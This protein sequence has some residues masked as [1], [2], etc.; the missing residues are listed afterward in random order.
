MNKI[1]LFLMIIL[2]L[3]IVVSCKNSE[4]KVNKDISKR[5]SVENDTYKQELNI[6]DDNYRTYY[7]VFLYSYYDSNG[8]GI[9]DING[10]IEKLDYINDGD[11]ITDTDLGFNGIW[12][13]PIMPSTTYHKYDVTDYYSIDEQYGTI[14]DF[15]YLVKE[16]N[17]RGIKLIIDMIFNHTSSKHPWFLSALQSL[18]IEPCGKETCAH[19][20]LCREHNKYVNYYNFVEERPTSGIYYPTGKGWY[21]EGVFWDQMPDLNLAD[22][23]LRKN[24][25]DVMSFWLNLGVGGFRL[26]AA[27]EYYSGA[28]SKN[29]E[30][31]S[32]ISEFVKSKSVD[33]YIVAEVW[34]PFLIYSKYYKSGIDSV[35]D[36][37]FAKEDGKIVKTLNYSDV[38]NSG[39]AYADALLLAD[40]TFKGYNTNAI[41]APFFT[42]HDTGRAAGFFSN[43]MNK[44]K[45]AAGMNLFM[46]GSAFVYYGEE[47]GMKGS[48]KDENKRAPMYW[49][50]DAKAKGTTV[51]P[52]NMEQVE[53]IYPSLE[54]QIKDPNSIYNYY[55]RAIRIRNE[56][57]EIA[58]GTIK[59]ISGVTDIDICGI[60]KTYK[61]S[62]I[63]ILYN[64]SKEVKTLDL[65]D[66]GINIQGI[67][68][69]VSATG[70]EV[71]LN[72][73]TVILPPYSIVILK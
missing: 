47:L 13:M 14:D 43:D 4:D 2:V 10:L 6:I 64:I 55:K 49:S 7:E 36:F 67:R 50:T 3:S 45:M 21:Y 28:P 23:N 71:T 39:S 73:N 60:T 52:A 8:D 11:P 9:G 32:W 63:T 16:C 35:F 41:D 59:K 26:D 38:N 29:I 54:V 57:P 44:L 20:Q 17:E 62:K 40:S 69:Y 53:H 18:P 51:G 5:K 33:N 30:V 24:L 70:E 27:K 37:A 65:V 12:L 61:E 19:P 56:N 34:D 31:L 15:K 1:K 72:D 68:G 46:N 48:G 22:E 66:S 25:E 58:R 42:N